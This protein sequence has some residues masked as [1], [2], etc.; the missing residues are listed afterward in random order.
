MM[1]WIPALAGATVGVMALACVSGDDSVAPVP[2]FDG[3]SGVDGGADATTVHD[4]CASDTG[5]CNSCAT[6][7]TDPSNACS[8]FTSGCTQFDAAR[9]PQHPAL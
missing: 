7:A 4:A 8:P 1:R 9:V 2:A 3:G 6:P 5:K